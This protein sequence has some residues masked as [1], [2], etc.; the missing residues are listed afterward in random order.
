MVLMRS[1]YEN[2][3]IG[4]GSSSWAENMLKR[5]KDW[6]TLD[7]GIQLRI[8]GALEELPRASVRCVAEAMHTPAKVQTPTRKNSNVIQAQLHVL[9]ACER[10]MDIALA[11]TADQ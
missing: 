6:A 8:Q 11:I 5:K 10:I 1:L 3:A 7:F 9:A 2:G 4:A